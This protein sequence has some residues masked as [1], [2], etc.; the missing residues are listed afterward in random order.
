MKKLQRHRLFRTRRIV[1]MIRNGIDGKRFPSARKMAHELEVSWDTVIRD[2]DYL[3]DDEGAPIAYDASRKGYYL[4]RPGWSLRPVSLTAREA[5]A[6]AMVSHMFQP[7]RGTPLEKDVQGLYA[8]IGLAMEGDVSGP[9][10]R[11]E[12]AVSFIADDFVPIDAARWTRLVGLTRQRAPVRM[13]YITFAGECRRYDLTPVHVF[14]YHGN[15][16]VAAF[17]RDRPEVRTFAMSRV[18]AIRELGESGWAPAEFDSATYAAEAY[19]I[20]GGEKALRV[21][22]RASRAIAAYMAERMWHPSQ[23]VT[24]RRDGS[25]DIAFTTRGRKEVVRW[26]LSWQPDLKVL[27]PASLGKRVREK[28]EEGIRARRKV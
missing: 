14:A 26:V 1:E 25:V 2:L 17:I 27:S 24:R 15:W 5:E 19:G 11:R 16:Y 3:R 13:T 12:D 6:L 22:V 7:F 23:R 4:E 21:R 9:F 10:M 8:K 20:M 18:R 28:M